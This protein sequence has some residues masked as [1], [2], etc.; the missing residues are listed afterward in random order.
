MAQKKRNI[1]IGAIDYSSCLG[2]NVGTPV[3]YR[4]RDAKLRFFF[5]KIAFLTFRHR[6]IDKRG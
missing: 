2:A 4:F 3:I 6:I 5:D 1:H